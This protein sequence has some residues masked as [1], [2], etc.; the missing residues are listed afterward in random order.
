MTALL[1]SLA[2]SAHADPS[3]SA[4]ESASW[5]LLTTKSHADAGEVQVFRATLDDVDCFRGLATTDAPADKMAEVVRDIDSVPQWSSAGVSE[6]KLLSSEPGRIEYYE[7]LDVPGWTMASDRFWFL[8]STFGEEG[9]THA[10]RW[11][12]LDEG[13]DHQA[14]YAD[15]KSRHPK[16]VEP[17]VN[18]GGW[19]FHDRGAERQI[20]YIVCTVP[21]GSIPAA[22]QNAATR[23][24][25]PDTVG[26]VVRDA[27]RRAGS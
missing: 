23:K 14:V 2:I 9:E 17:T 19:Y 5:S 25:L 6:A 24:T 11:G 22:V 8:W 16:A 13:G 4:M 10:F 1:L 20:E 26:D 12:R 27:R 18:V 21:G 15:L 7:Y 3:H